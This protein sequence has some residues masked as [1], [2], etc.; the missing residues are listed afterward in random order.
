MEIKDSQIMITGASRG[1]GFAF[2]KVCAENKAHLHLVVRNSDEQLSKDLMAAGA[3]SVTLWQA[4]LANKKSVEDLVHQITTLNID[5]LFN[6]A[7]MLTG[8]LLEEQSQEEIDSM[9]QV[10][11][12]SLIQLTR[13]LLPR[14]LQRKN[15]KIIN[16]ASVAALM[17]FPMASTYS[18]SKAAVL[19]F[20]RCLEIELEGT[21][22]STLLLIT[23]GI[24][25]RMFDEIEIR[26]GKNIKVP[27][28]SISPYK[29]AGMIKEA[30]L[31]D[32]RV[33]EPHGL[34]GFG[35]NVAK[36]L[37][38]SFAWVVRSRFKR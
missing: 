24:K 27:N 6:N 12:A 18:A 20:T 37:P 8:G 14:M 13:A 4:D 30:V 28:L 35:L 25:T 15:G 9:L 1:I 7:G 29:F 19:A 11:V 34:T 2:A 17:H 3:A 36:Y 21:G 16:N 38:K 23:P 31:N 26:Y 33:L 10:N 5:I 22:V 32:M